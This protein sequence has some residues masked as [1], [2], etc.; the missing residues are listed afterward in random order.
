MSI[1]N[2][3]LRVGRIDFAN[4]TPLFMA[5]GE[6]GGVG[7]SYLR[8]VP[9]DLNQRLR[10]GGVDLSP[11]SS[12]EYLRYPELYGFLPDHSISSIGPVESVLLLSRRP[13]EEL[14]GRAVALSASSATS[15]VLLRVLLERHV[16]I[17]PDYVDPGGR[18]EAELQIGDAALREARRKVWPRVYDLGALWF[19]RTATPFVFGLWI[20][21][22]DAFE[23]RPRAVRSFYRDLV[24]ARHLAYRS[25]PSYARRCPEASWMGEDE[26]LNYWQTISYDL[27][28]WHLQGLRRFAQEA[29]ALG[30]IESVP[31]LE[32]L[33]V[34]PEEAP[35]E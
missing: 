7:V 25:Y 12:I 1:S 35:D 28:A 26:L 18:A 15:V 31:A 19:E 3:P 16:G 22:R 5:L 2:Q 14:D 10:Q 6:G 33:P 17:R 30:A 13:I 24:R 4:C 34:E 23:A 29:S 20:C 27:T 21:R 8:G 9:T 11:S 32:P